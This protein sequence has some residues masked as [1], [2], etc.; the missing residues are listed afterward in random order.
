MPT[1][2]LPQ[3]LIKHNGLPMS[4][5]EASQRCSWPKEPIFC[6]PP[7]RHSK[8]LLDPKHRILMS[9][10]DSHKIFWM[11]TLSLPQGL[12][13]NNGLPMSNLEACQRCSWPK[14]PIYC[15]PYTRHSKSLLDLKPPPRPCGTQWVAMSDLV[16]KNKCLG[17]CLGCLN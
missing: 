12:M 6:W 7:T 3:G 9:K 4:S 17:L 15:W 16:G 8:I 14:D 1:L 10:L 5:L 2:S 11:P 13:K